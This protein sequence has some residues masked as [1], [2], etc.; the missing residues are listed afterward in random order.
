MGREHTSL[1]LTE[2]DG[3]GPTI[4][5]GIGA[6]KKHTPAQQKETP[7]NARHGG[8]RMRSEKKPPEPGETWG[9]EKQTPREGREKKRTINIR[10]TT[11]RV[12]SHG[13]NS[14]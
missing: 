4:R 7:E 12:R 10:A 14:L 11:P 2:S 8:R 3:W 6:G 13:S 1:S 5:V 9:Q